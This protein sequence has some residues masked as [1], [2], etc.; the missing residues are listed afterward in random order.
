[1]VLGLTCSYTSQLIPKPVPHPR[2]S[3]IAANDILCSD[4]LNRASFIFQLRSCKEIRSVVRSEIGPKQ[5]VLHSRA[6]R[7]RRG[8]TWS[9]F[10]LSEM[11]KSDFDRIGIIV[12]RFGR[13][14][15]HTF[16][17]NTSLD[18]NVRVLGDRVQEETLDPS[19]VEDH[20]LEPRDARGGVGNPVAALDLPVVVW[21]PQ[22]NLQHVVGLPPHSVSEV[23]TVEDFKRAAL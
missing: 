18:S 12:V 6:I 3:A 2:M 10:L 14:E 4:R 5:P 7:R 9:R 21:V 11:T 23:E 19:L 20:L 1:M 15:L 13:I 8:S 22:V 16:R 17:Q